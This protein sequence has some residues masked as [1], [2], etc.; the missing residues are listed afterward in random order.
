MRAPEDCVTMDDVRAGIDRLDAELVRLLAERAA[1][2]DRAAEIKHGAGLPARIDARIGEVLA[3]VRGHALRHGLPPGHVE[4]IWSDLIE[5]SIA[6][7]ETRLGADT[8]R[9][10]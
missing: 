1:L 5:W 2:I 7:E 4:K 9:E 3:N 8:G 6:R 10:E